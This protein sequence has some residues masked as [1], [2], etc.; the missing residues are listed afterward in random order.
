MTTAP[1]YGGNEC[2]ELLDGAHDGTVN[3][4][5]W[6]WLLFFVALVGL[7]GMWVFHRRESTSKNHSSS[8]TLSLFLQQ[9]DFISNPLSFSLQHMIDFNSNMSHL[10]I[11]I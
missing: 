2:T 7:V 8:N 6:P 9:I 4:C 1:G 5:T 11:F 3:D 10:F